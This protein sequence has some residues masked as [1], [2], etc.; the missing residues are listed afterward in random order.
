MEL[1]VFVDKNSLLAAPPANGSSNRR[2][3]QVKH[4][5]PPEPHALFAASASRKAMEEEHLALSGLTTR[6]YWHLTMYT[7]GALSRRFDPF[8][9]TELSK[10]CYNNR[11]FAMYAQC[12]FAHLTMRYECFVSC[13]RL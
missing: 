3:W 2:A 10:H 12:I 4:P 8:A 1:D 13:V 5:F 6:T 11:L 9:E 7:H